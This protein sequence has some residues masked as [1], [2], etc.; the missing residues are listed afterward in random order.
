MAYAEKLGK[1]IL[2]EAN[3]SFKYWHSSYSC[4]KNMRK[5]F[6]DKNQ[7]LEILNLFEDDRKEVA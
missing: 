6:F 3:H 7:C 1:W 2:R 5:P 4:R